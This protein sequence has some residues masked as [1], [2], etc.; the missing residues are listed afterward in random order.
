MALRGTTT[1]NAE[2]RIIDI[3]NNATVINATLLQS[4]LLNVSGATT[5]GAITAAGSITATGA[6]SGASVTATGVVGGADVTASDQLL[7]TSTTNPQA[8][9]TNGAQSVSLY[10][11]TTGNVLMTKTGTYINFEGQIIDFSPYIT[12]AGALV[13]TAAQIINTTIDSDPEGNVNWTFPDADDVVAAI[14]NCR[15]GSE[16]TTT[17]YNNATG[18]SAEVVTFVAGTNQTIRSSLGTLTEGINQIGF[19]R[20]VVTNVT[21]LNE[22]YTTYIINP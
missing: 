5:T 22:A 3:G 15:V 2:G 18:A 8:R 17:L 12:T 9:I 1:Y 20:S 11:N 4:N 19:A 16:F 14:P 13:L 21:A 7:I 6:I 10:V